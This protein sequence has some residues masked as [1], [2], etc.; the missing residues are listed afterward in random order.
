M[1]PNQSNIRKC[2]CDCHTMMMFDIVLQLTTVWKCVADG[3][4]LPQQWISQWDESGC[5]LL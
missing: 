3:L 5:I 1:V 4:P 2:V